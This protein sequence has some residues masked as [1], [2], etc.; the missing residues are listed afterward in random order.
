MKLRR[1]EMK[2]RKNEMKLR[3]NFLTPTWK[4]KNIQVDILERRGSD[5][6]PRK[7]M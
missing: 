4:M 3:R 1:N 7:D 6:F 5:K 2:L